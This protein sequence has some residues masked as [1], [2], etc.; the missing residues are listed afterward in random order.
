MIL[1]TDAGEALFVRL[2]A[3][4]GGA[5]EAETGGGLEL[6]CARRVLGFGAGF[7][8]AGLRRVCFMT[9]VGASEDRAGAD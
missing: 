6:L 8:G 9:W 2:G 3:G 4:G 5:T 7:G 1:L